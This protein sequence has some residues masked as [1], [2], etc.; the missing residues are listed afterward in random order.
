MFGII[1]GILVVFLLARKRAFK[2]FTLAICLVT[3]LTLVLLKL[4]LSQGGS[5]GFTLLI[6]CVNGFASIGAYSVVFEFA[7]DISPDVGEGM[8]SG[9]INMAANTLGG[10]LILLIEQLGKNLTHKRDYLNEAEIVML[11]SVVVA[12][13]LFCCVKTP[14][15][16]I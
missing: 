3:L 16:H 1:G 9:V 15:Q 8:S 7:V 11:I 13:I 12:L 4:N 10:L 14:R 6:I 5:H 2:T